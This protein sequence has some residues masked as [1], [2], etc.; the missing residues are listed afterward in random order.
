[1]PTIFG[2]LTFIKEDKLSALVILTENT[3][4][5]GSSQYFCS[6]E[7]FSMK[8]FLT[9]GPELS[10][11]TSVLSIF[12]CKKKVKPRNGLEKNEQRNK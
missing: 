3:N 8:S 7:M 1:M 9:S 4:E 12:R 11:Y 5:F 6:A 10:L 2:I